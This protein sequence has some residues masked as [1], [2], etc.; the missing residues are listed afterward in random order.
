[1]SNEGL[2]ELS[3]EIAR[4]KRNSESTGEIAKATSRFDETKKKK[5]SIHHQ[6]FNSL[7][8]V[9]VTSAH[10]KPTHTLRGPAVVDDD[11]G[12]RLAKEKVRTYCTIVQLARL[13][14]QGAYI[15][16][17]RPSQDAGRIFDIIQKHTLN[18]RDLVNEIALFS[19]PSEEEIERHKR[20][21]KD[22]ESL[23]D[24]AVKVHGV[25]VNQLDE[26]QLTSNFMKAINSSTKPV[27]KQRKAD[28]PKFRKRIKVDEPTKVED[29]ITDNAASKVR[30]WKRSKRG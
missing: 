21:L 27:L 24:L 25:A 3:R 17:N 15:A 1:M 12:D 2:G 4:V 30:S 20:I 13:N 18:Y 14:E 5:N 29:M 23:N 28:K 19:N 11:L 26:R 6:L 8:D 7:W 16:L 10:L 22:L 9:T